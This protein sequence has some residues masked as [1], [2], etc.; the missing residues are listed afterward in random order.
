MADEHYEVPW[1]I[2]AY[3]MGFGIIEFVSGLALALFGA[4]AAVWYQA[5][6]AKELSEDPH[7][8]LARYSQQVIPGIL[9]HHTYLVLYLM[10]LGGAKIAGA[11]GLIFGRN[12]G[13]D[14]LVGLT[15]ALF[16]FQA[17]DL[18]MHPS[19]VNFLYIGTGLLIAMY[20]VEWRPHVW[21]R[22]L[23]VKAHHLVWK[24]VKPTLS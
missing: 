5:S 11:T 16:P 14:L 20:L 3:K 9:T 21:A 15:I 12:W 2:I 1:Y 17:I 7:D 18:V 23:A 24:P 4:R 22:R 8:L 10:L 6:V 19:L 13:V